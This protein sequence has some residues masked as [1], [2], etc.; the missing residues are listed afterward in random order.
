MNKVSSEFIRK[1][2]GKENQ[3][4]FAKKLG[5]SQARLSLLE[6]GKVGLSLHIGFLLV[7]NCNVEPKK[8]FD[9]HKKSLKEKKNVRK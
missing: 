9:I 3:I 7:N 6:T 1:L 4:P 5:I 8:I 2:R